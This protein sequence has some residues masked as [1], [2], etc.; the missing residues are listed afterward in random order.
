M[1]RLLAPGIDCL[2]APLL[3]LLAV[4]LRK[5]FGRDQH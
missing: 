1:E 2:T 5:I 4:V 3:F